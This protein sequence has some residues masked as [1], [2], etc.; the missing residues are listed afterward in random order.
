MIIV[1]FKIAG[2]LAPPSLTIRIGSN[3]AVNKIKEFFDFLQ[4][5]FGFVLLYIGG[6]KRQKL[7]RVPIYDTLQ[8][9]LRVFFD[10]CVFIDEHA[11]FGT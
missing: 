11:I 10:N 8:H 4:C 2:T 3:I 5:L 6:E 7:L 9:L 1:E